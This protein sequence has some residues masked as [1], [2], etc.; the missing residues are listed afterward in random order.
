[1]GFY[2][3]KNPL[4]KAIFGDIVRRYFL[5]FKKEINKKKCFYFEHIDHNQPVANIT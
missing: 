1:M 2:G 5:I 4:P 3:C